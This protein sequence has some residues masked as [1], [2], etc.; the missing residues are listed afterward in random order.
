MGL[1]GSAERG[2]PERGRVEIKCAF[3]HNKSM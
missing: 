2:R 3:Q 1:R